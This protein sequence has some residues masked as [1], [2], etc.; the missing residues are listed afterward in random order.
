MQS[1]NRLPSLLAA[2]LS[3]AL[4]GAAGAQTTHTGLPCA[5]TTVTHAMGQTC[6]PKLPRRV[7]TL[8]W[9]HTENLLALGVQ[10]VGA[11]DLSGY[12]QW[13]R[14]PAALNASVQDVGTRQQPSLERIRALKPDLIITTRLRATQNYAGLSAIAPTIVFDPYAGG[15][16]LA[17]MRA[18][19]QITTRLLGRERTAQQVLSNLDA[20]LDRVR[21]DLKRGGRAGQSF[22]FAQAYTARGGAPTLRLFTGNSMLSELLTR[23]GLVNAWKAPAQPYGFSEVS[24]EALAGL[25]TTH[26]LYVAQQEDDVFGAPSVRPLWQALPFVKAGRAHALNERTWTFGGPLSALTLTGEISRALSGR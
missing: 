26:F 1:V 12:A 20:R 8:E 14:V 19:F 17:E 22:V 9:T 21:Q 25:N 10:P 16:Q 5:G 4:T 2:L 7:V 24:L 6:V 23:V 3:A 15:S 11:A 18:T 13:V